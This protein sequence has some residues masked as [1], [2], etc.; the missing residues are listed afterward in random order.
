MKVLVLMSGGIDSACCVAFYR[1]AGHEVAGVFVD[2]AQPVSQQEEQSARAIAHHYTIPLHVVRCSGPGKEFK[3]EIA[4]RNAFL[5][6]AALLQSPHRTNLIALGIHAGTRYYDC[7][8][9]FV[10]HINALLSGY[11]NGQLVLAAPFLH[12]SKRTVYQF[13]VTNE[14]PVHLTWSCEV[15][16]LEPCGKCTSCE[17]RGHL[18]VCTT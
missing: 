4:G 14:I 10:D 17:D 7:S 8:E 18:S 11:C 13:C 16:P 15:G 6:F 1:Q 2:Y 3:D 5:I 12:W 9:H